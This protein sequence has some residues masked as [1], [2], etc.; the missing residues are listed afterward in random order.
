MK[1][2]LS[3]NK[4]PRLVQKLKKQGKKIT[5]VGGCFDVLHP[6]HVIFL[7]KAKRQGDVLF[8]LLESDEKVKKLKGVRRPVHSQK[9]RARALSALKAVD[10]VIPLPTIEKEKS[11]DEIVLKIKPDI[12]ATAYGYENNKHHKRSA[13]LTGAKIKYV[14]KIVGNHS[15]SAILNR[16]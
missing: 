12:I 16:E 2:E 6:G 13:K 10:Y 8:V 15:T 4:I 5:L 1:G 3:V 9:E 14:T 7:E 11:Y